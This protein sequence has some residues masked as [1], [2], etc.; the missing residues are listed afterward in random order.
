M[1]RAIGKRFLDTACRLSKIHKIYLSLTVIPA[2]MSM[3]PLSHLVASGKR[4]T[5]E[6]WDCRPSDIS[7]SKMVLRGSLSTNPVAN[8]D[9]ILSTGEACDGLPSGP[10]H[11]KHIRR[12]PRRPPIRQRQ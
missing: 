8:P 12:P 4:N 2:A 11:G 3:S 6:S 7:K 5:R 1:D 9:Q 10:S